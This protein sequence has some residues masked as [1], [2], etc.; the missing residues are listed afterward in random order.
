MDVQWAYTHFEKQENKNYYHKMFTFCSISSN[1]S[2]EFNHIDTGYY[3]EFLNK[4][5]VNFTNVIVLV[6]SVYC[7]LIF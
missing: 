5:F 3:S 2:L 4:S 1:M 7:I 6:N